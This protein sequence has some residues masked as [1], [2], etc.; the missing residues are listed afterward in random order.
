MK[1]LVRKHVRVSPLLQRYRRFLKRACLVASTQ[2]GYASA[3]SSWM[4]TLSEMLGTTSDS[5]RE[6]FALANALA[7]DR[8]QLRAERSI[9]VTAATLSLSYEET[10]DVLLE[11]LHGRTMMVQSTRLAALGRFYEWLQDEGLIP[12]NHVAVIRPNLELRNAALRPS[13]LKARR[14]KIWRR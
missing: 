1:T 4:F 12:V 5:K 10:C 8:L 6:R 14:S 13:L 11:W 2:R 9:S 3:A 7:G